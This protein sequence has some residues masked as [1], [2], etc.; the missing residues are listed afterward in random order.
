M[1]NLLMFPLFLIITYSS[2]HAG[3][4]VSVDASVGCTCNL[5]TMKDVAINKSGEILQMFANPRGIPGM[6]VN[7]L[8]SR[9]YKQIPGI[10]TASGSFRIPE[11][12]NNEHVSINIQWTENYIEH[13]SELFYTTN[14]YSP[15]YEYVWTRN[16]LDEQI[17][18]F[19]IPFDH[20][21][22]TFSITADHKNHST[23]RIQVDDQIADLNI[24][25][26]TVGKEWKESFFLLLE[27]HNQYPNCG[28]P[29]ITKGMSEWKDVVLVKE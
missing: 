7:A 11:N 20:A 10:Y 12:G 24:P 2:W 23:K 27:T 5:P 13:F 18:L 15:L 6:F 21:W 28:S 14:R 1:K 19:K 16:K 29:L 3:F 8:A 9:K 17:K 26:G 4:N 22:H 25:M